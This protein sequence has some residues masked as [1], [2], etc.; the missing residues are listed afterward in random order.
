MENMLT[1]FIEKIMSLSKIRTIS[2]N[3]IFYAK[4]ALARIKDPSQSSPATRIFNTLLG[5][6]EYCK[7]IA[8]NTKFISI[9]SPIEVHLYGGMDPK[10]D[11]IQFHY[12]KTQLPVKNFAFD[13]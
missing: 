6:V 1:N 12:A 3:E 7:N 13:I 4:S 10:N 2:I 11:N 8:D 5:L 9:L